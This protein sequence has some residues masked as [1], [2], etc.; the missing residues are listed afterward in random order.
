MSAF[1]FAAAMDVTGIGFKWTYAYWFL[2]NFPIMLLTIFCLWLIL[3]KLFPVN[4]EEETAGF[5][6][7]RTELHSLGNM[8]AAEWRILLILV[9]TL[10]GWVTE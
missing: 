4:M 9:L 1:V 2:I 3:R 8:K 7:I 10:L 6:F 5:D